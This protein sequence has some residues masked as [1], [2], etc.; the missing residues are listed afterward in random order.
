MEWSPQQEDALAAINRWVKNP[1]GQQVFRLFGYAGT[2]K[3]TLA[4]TI[5]EN[6]EGQVM[7]GA[8]TGKAAHVLKTKG[9]DAQTIHAMIYR[10]R[11][12][13]KVKLRQLEAEIFRLGSMNPQPLARLR[14]LR[15]ELDREKG[16]LAQPAF[17]LNPTTSLRE[18][19]LVIIDE[20]SM[21]D[22]RMGGDLL[23]FERPVLVLG[24]PAQL[25]PVM[26][27]G[28]FTASKPD[29]M[30]TDIHRQAR[31]NPII[32]MATTV[33]EGG[34]LKIGEYGESRVINKADVTSEMAMDAEQIIVGKNA[35]RR[36]ANDRA[37]VLL[38]RNHPHPIPEDRLVIL[39]NNHDLGL[40]NGAMW[41]VTGVG[42]VDQDS[43]VMDIKSIDEGTE[44]T[45]EFHA[46]Y[47]NGED[48][49]LAWWERGEKNEADYGYAITAHKAQGSQFRS[50]F[51]FD[52]SWVFRSDA[53]KWLYTAITRAAER[54]TI[55]KT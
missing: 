28:F 50:V 10:T 43:V 14:E 32:A 4:K 48:K 38:G 47:F 1:N 2:G 46:H 51:M 7:F 15:E 44:L 37:R 18:A 36:A 16:E 35:T 6:I 12:K 23:S 30:L 19:S 39:R 34:R 54:I 20:C 52:E 25:P 53:Q 22:G 17:S 3:T 13:S 27:G 8:Y 29:F 26:G 24:D 9:C 55:V 31:D 5:A 21:I 33:R 11:D 49:K 42:S 41:D 45:A 40:L